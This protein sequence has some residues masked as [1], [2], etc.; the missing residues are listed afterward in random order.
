MVF[1]LRTICSSA[2]DRRTILS[3]ANCRKLHGALEYKKMADLPKYRC[4]EDPPFTHCRV[5]MFG[6]FV[7]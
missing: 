6:I 3:S 2:K 5:D 7:F 4:I 1:G